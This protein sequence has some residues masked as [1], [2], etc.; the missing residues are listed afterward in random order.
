[1]YKVFNLLCNRVTNNQQTYKF[2]YKSIYLQSFSTKITS[3]PNSSK[4]TTPMFCKKLSDFTFCR[5]GRQDF[6]GPSA[7]ACNPSRCEQPQILP[8]T[9]ISTTLAVVKVRWHATKCRAASRSYSCFRLPLV[10]RGTPLRPCLL[11]HPSD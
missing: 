1:M 2:Y 8:P 3:T 6:T 9:F 7:W 4:K 10:V 5:D 11:R